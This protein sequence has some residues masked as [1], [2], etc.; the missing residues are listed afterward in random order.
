MR[1]PLV[2]R[3]LPSSALAT[4]RFRLVALVLLAALVALFV[5]AF[6]TFANPTRGE[7]PGLS[8]SLRLARQ[9]VAAQP[10]AR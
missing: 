1:P 6:Q 7:D 3:E 8:N 10:A 9:P 5:V 4:W 2:P